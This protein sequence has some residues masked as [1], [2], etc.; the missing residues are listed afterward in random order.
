MLSLTPAALITGSR[1]GGG[2]RP[3]MDPPHRHP[4]GCHRHSCLVR[5]KVKQ[6]S[7]E[8]QGWDSSPERPVPRL[9]QAGEVRAHDPCVSW[10]LN[11]YKPQ[12]YLEMTGLK[13]GSAP[14]VRPSCRT[15]VRTQ[16]ADD[17]K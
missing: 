10:S 3:R 16:A 6:H 13:L 15:V 9:K 17:T 8:E 1:E 2:C 7:D 4:W 14:A 5:R 12:A 11:T